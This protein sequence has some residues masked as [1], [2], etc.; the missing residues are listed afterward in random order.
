MTDTYTPSALQAEKW[1]AEFFQYGLQ[2]MFFA[3]FIGDPSPIEDQEGKP[4]EIEISTSRNALIQ[5]KMDLLGGIGDKVTFP[6]L[7]PL[8]LNGRVQLGTD[9]TAMVLEG[10]EEAISAYSWKATLKEWGHSV[11]DTGALARKQPAFSWDTGMRM[12]LGE[13]F[14]TKLDQATYAALAGI[15]FTGDNS[16]ALLAA[17]A[18]AGTA[19]KLTGGTAAGTFTPR[20]TDAGIASGEYLSLEMISYARKSIRTQQPLIRP[21][22]ISGQD[23]YF[24]FISPTQAYDLKSDAGAS[25]VHTWGEAMKYAMPRGEKNPLFTK[26]MGAWDGVLIFEYDGVQTRTG[27]GGSEVLTSVG[28]TFDT[29]DNAASGRKIAR[30][31]FCGATACVHAYGSKPKFVGKKFDYDRLEGLSVQTLVSVEKPEFNSVD[32]GVMVLDT[33][34]SS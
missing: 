4:S 23:W 33:A 34:V 29:G 3:D 12:A 17:N 6:Q 22:R 8:A 28:N 21:I 11:R 25:V 27:D 26:A 5:V 10:Y 31:L 7:A 19:R 14:G 20:T 30:G 32:Y 9:T 16:K 13:W 24:L 15:A 1:S 2:N 18:P